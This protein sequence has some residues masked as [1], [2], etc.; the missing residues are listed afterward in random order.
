MKIASPTSSTIITV[1]V[2]AALYLPHGSMA[3]TTNNP[4]T[5]ALMRS[6]P[7]QLKSFNNPM[8]LST[9]RTLK[10]SILP[11]T[12]TR[13]NEKS[14]DDDDEIQ[15]LKSMA[16]QLRAE[17]AKLEA[18]KA[19]SLRQAAQKAFDQFDT[20]ND[21]E[22][23]VA[24]LKAGLEKTFKIELSQT[25]AEQLMKTFDVSGDGTLQPEE[26]VTEAV[27]RNKLDALLREE[28]ELAVKAEQEAKLAEEAQ[29][30]AQARLDFLNEKPPTNS[31]KFFSILPYLFPLMDGLQYGRF[32]FGGESENPL[33]IF[34]AV[35]YALYRSIPFSG[36]VAFLALNFL[37]NNPKLNRLVRFNM[38]QA[39]FVD[40][41]LI[42]P[43]LVSGLFTVLLSVAGTA[44]PPGMKEIFDDAIFVTLL[45]TLAYC[46]A[47][48]LL[49]T[50][51]NKLPLI[52]NA[53]SDRMPTVDMFDEEGRYIPRELRE[54][55]IK[56]EDEKKK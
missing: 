4:R 35:L 41:S 42:F 30:L 31:D 48:S 8:L 20:N 40:I 39:I 3:F 13:L 12:T 51:P 23:S 1:A 25:R 34:L 37:A 36:F 19:E 18:E 38:Q 22:I 11:T 43:G 55:E 54:E 10:R 7:S 45:L 2:S 17:A 24:E 44:P 53:V 5:T 14:D 28:K 26:M 32:I 9:M 47:S 50:E 27:F 56:D 16:A 33:V 49:G 52:S 29:A 15:R 21:G 46:T 6:N